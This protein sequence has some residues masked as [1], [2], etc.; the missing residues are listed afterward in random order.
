MLAASVG[1]VGG[2]TGAPIIKRSSL[3][4]CWLYEA[5]SSG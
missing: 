3:P 4:R 5:Q 2:A 1:T